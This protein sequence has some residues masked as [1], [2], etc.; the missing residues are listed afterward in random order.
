MICT[1]SA[2]SLKNSTII[3]MTCKKALNNEEGNSVIL[4][5]VIYPFG[6]GLN[7]T[8]LSCEGQWRLLCLGSDDV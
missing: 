1:L 4:I 5:Y 7:L 3:Y 6:L 8:L 2:K